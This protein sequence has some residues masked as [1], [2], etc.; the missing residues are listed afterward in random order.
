[1]R[2][3]SPLVN[4]ASVTVPLALVGALIGAG[5]LRA[6]QVV[7]PRAYSGVPHML[8][9]SLKPDGAVLAGRSMPCD[10][11]RDGYDLIALEASLMELKALQPDKQHIVIVP[12]GAVS[13]ADLM[14]VMD[15]VRPHFP[16]QT[17]Q[18]HD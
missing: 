18:P 2:G 3:S 8:V 6:P 5:A 16:L 13:Y 15:A 11:G 1:M 4:L 12:D 7:E 14:D 9:L 10:C 17:V